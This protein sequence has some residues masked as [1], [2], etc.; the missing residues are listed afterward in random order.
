MIKKIWNNPYS[1]IIKIFAI[2]NI[3][4]FEVSIGLW[5]RIRQERL[6]VRADFTSLYNSF[7]KMRAGNVGKIF[8]LNLQSIYQHG[9]LG[10][11][12]LEGGVYPLQYPPI[13]SFFYSPL[14]FLPFNIAFIIWTLVELGLLIWL[15]YLLN[16]IFSDWSKNERLVLII[17]ILAFFPLAHT[18]LTGQFS[19][20][21]LICLVQ[22]YISMKNAKPVNAG[23]WMALLLIK[24]QIVLIPSVMTLNKRFWRGAVS[25]ILTFITLLFLSSL[26]FGLEPWIKYFQLLVNMN[27]NFGNYAFHP[28][29]EYTL[30]GI[31]SRILV[32]SQT[33]TINLLSNVALLLGMVFVLYLWFQGIP[34]NT[35][36]FKLYFAF[37]ITISVFLSLHMYSYDDLILVLPAAIFY[38]YLRQMGFTRQVYSIFVVISPLV[39]FM[40][41]FTSFSLFGFLLLPTAIIV[42][43]LIWLIKYIILDY[44]VEQLV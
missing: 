5:V 27:I 24:P 3:I 1:T 16:Q 39:F 31:L 30:K 44:R 43:L 28:E 11:I 13:I 40:G 41:I 23:I 20:F 33:D 29:L 21:L 26:L 12:N 8:E 6:F 14:S 37:T 19:L 17:T 42:L 7:V 38:D 2:I 32:N 25:A 34:L 9:I 4:L 22:V 10:G 36:R 18:I 35:P 15:I